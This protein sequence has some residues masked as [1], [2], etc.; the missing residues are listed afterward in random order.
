MD[1]GLQYRRCLGAMYFI[2]YSDND[3][4]GDINMSK[5]MRHMLFVLG[6]CF[7]KWQSIKEQVVALSSCEVEYIT[8]T[9][10]TTQALWLPRLLCDLLGK[11]A[12]V[13]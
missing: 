5:S 7:I 2:N 12:E 13:V 3:H 4:T 9:T 10:A 1:Y 6:K 11:D 8:V